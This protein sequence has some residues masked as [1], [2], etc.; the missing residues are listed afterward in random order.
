M[1]LFYAEYADYL[2]GVCSWYIR[3]R[4]DVHD[5]M[6]ESLIKI[7]TKISA[8]EYRGMGSLKAWATRIVINESLHFLREKHP[9]ML[10]DRG[11]DFP[12]IVEEGPPDVDGL[13]VEQL[14]DMILELPPG[15]RAVFNLFAI[16][17]KSHKEIAEMLGIKP[18][19]SASQFFKARNMLAKM[20]HERITSNERKWK[21]N[22]WTGCASG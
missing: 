21:S 16:E 19:T 17:G 10:M 15:Y 9:F 14:S 1:D 5:V 18:D 4:E 6:Q 22:G 2:T 8:F 11:A 12:D 7:F 20:I 13:S 3:D